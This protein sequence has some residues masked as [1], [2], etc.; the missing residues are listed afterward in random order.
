MQSEFHSSSTFVQIQIP[1]KMYR[2]VLFAVV[3]ALGCLAL[4]QVSSDFHFS[5]KKKRT[6]NL[7]TI[8]LIPKIFYSRRRYKKLVLLRSRPM[9]ALHMLMEHHRVMEAMVAITVPL[10]ATALTIHIPDTNPTDIN[11][12]GNLITADT[13]PMGNLIMD[14]NPMG[15]L[16]MDTNRLMVLIIAVNMTVKKQDSI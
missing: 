4:V 11:P 16:I 1:L 9:V 5:L 6:L 14:T 2:A 10:P 13:N 3:A 8:K 15:N 7:H 12:M